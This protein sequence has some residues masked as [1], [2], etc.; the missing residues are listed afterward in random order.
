MMQAV[1]K[2]PNFKCPKF[3]VPAKPS[4]EKSN[5]TENKGKQE[6]K[7]AKKKPLS[8]EIRADGD[9]N[10]SATKQ[11]LKANPSGDHKTE[12]A[13]IKDTFKPE[14]VPESGDNV[15]TSLLKEQEIAN[16]NDG[17]EGDHVKAK[18]LS[19]TV[20]EKKVIKKKNKTKTEFSVTPASDIQKNDENKN[21]A[22]EKKKKENKSVVQKPKKVKEKK[23]PKEPKVTLPV[24]SL[25]DEEYTAIFDAT[26]EN[27]MN[28]N[29][30]EWA[31]KATSPSK[32]KEPVKKKYSITVGKKEKK[33]EVSTQESCPRPSTGMIEN[34]EGSNLRLFL[35]YLWTF[36]VV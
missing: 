31:P 25:T 26:I 35:P 32:K 13:E 34:T 6:K 21:N 15:K 7:E 18:Q 11:F 3:S 10:V 20:S 36:Y 27:A 23:E 28:L 14:D 29:I 19:T 9:S 4:S 12:S 24:R 2:K 1:P 8:V 30:D 16:K 17:L 22:K 5:S 33:T